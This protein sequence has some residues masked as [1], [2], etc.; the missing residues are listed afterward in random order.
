MGRQRAEY[1]IM[2]DYTAQDKVSQAIYHG[3]KGEIPANSVTYFPIAYRMM[4]RDSGNTI[5]I[6]WTSYGSPDWAG[7][8]AGAAI[9]FGSAFVI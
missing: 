7:L 3:S 1:L 9:L 6:R 2:A 8:N 4:A 5:W